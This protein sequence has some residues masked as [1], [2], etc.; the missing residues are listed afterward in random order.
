MLK[1]IILGALFF[2]LVFEAVKIFSGSS[3]LSASSY[4]LF[5]DLLARL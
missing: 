5:N 4:Y 2:E 1:S 3:F